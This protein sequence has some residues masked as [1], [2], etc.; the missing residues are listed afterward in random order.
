MPPV[1]ELSATLVFVGPDPECPAALGPHTVH[2]VRE[3]PAFALYTSG[4][5][6]QAQIKMAGVGWHRAARSVMCQYPFLPTQA[7]RRI[8]KALVARCSATYDFD[9]AQANTKSFGFAG[10]RSTFQNEKEVPTMATSKEITI[11]MEDRPGTLEKF[12]R[13]L[14]EWRVNIV[15]F[16]SFPS[17][18]KSLVR[19]VVGVACSALPNARFTC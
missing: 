13:A 7:I 1:G 9:N 14:A 19:M 17:D 16:Y 5:A 8:E 4:L 11:Q 6:S 18:G 2:L 12:C 10:T 15:A 3:F